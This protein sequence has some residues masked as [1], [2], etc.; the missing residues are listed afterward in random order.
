MWTHIGILYTYTET[1]HKETSHKTS[2]M[3]DQIKFIPLNDHNITYQSSPGCLHVWAVWFSAWSTAHDKFSKLA[4]PNCYKSELFFPT[5]RCVC[6]TS[7]A[8]T[9][10]DEVVSTWPGFPLWRSRDVC[11]SSRTQDAQTTHGWPTLWRLTTASALI[12]LTIHTLIMLFCSRYL[13]S[14]SLSLCQQPA[15]LD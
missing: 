11:S 13:P 14:S 9:L 5:W 8:V 1:S 4:V 10:R 12:S 6:I 15:F 3:M 2:A 7:N